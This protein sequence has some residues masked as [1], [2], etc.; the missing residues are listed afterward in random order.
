MHPHANSESFPAYEL[1]REEDIVSGLFEVLFRLSEKAKPLWS[2][3]Q[4]AVD[5]NRRAAEDYVSTLFPFV[6]LVDGRV[7]P[8]IVAPAAS[9]SANSATNGASAPSAVI[10]PASV[11]SPFPLAFPGMIRRSTGTGRR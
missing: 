3:F 5:L 10:F 4:H 1:G 9:S 6:D 2:Q 7:P 11:I 8:A